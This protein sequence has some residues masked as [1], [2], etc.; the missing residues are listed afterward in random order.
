LK[1][2]VG[3][4]LHP[5]GTVCLETGRGHFRILEKKATFQGIFRAQLTG[6]CHF[7]DKSLSISID[8]VRVTRVPTLRRANAGTDALRPIPRRR[9]GATRSVACARSHAGARERERD[10]LNA[11]VRKAQ[12][13]AHAGRDGSISPYRVA[14]L[15]DWATP[16][17]SSRVPFA[18]PQRESRRKRDPDQKLIVPSRTTV[19]G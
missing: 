5:P 18:L 15:L 9:R 8:A 14:G 4:L 3:N 1:L 6:H 13:P 17:D 12:K 10:F 7:T 11:G 16:L 19:M 2:K